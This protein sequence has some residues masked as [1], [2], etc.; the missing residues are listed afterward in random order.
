MCV[1][2]EP[3]RLISIDASGVYKVNLY[4]LGAHR[5]SPVYVDDRVPAKDDYV[6]G[7]GGWS[8]S[9]TKALSVLLKALTKV[10]GG[11]DSAEGGSDV[12][13]L[14][15]MLGGKTHYNLKDR[16]AIYKQVGGKTE[17][18]VYEFFH[19]KLLLKEGSGDTLWTETFAPGHTPPTKGLSWN[20]TA[21]IG[22]GFKHEIR[23]LITGHAYT[24][25]A[26]EKLKF[27]EKSSCSRKVGTPVYAVQLRNPWGVR[28]GQ[29]RNGQ[30]TGTLGMRDTCW[31][32]C[33]VQRCV[34]K[35]GTGKTATCSWKP[36]VTLSP[37]AGKTMGTFWMLLDDFLG[38]AS[39][40]QYI[41]LLCCNKVKLSSSCKRCMIHAKFMRRRLTHMGEISQSLGP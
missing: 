20:R 14:Q 15:R 29:N 4:D 41:D 35:D 33:K 19:K 5:W 16:A 26:V 8:N 27:L 28:R 17:K 11:Y 9:K 6:S 30:W 25:M 10:M 38:Q 24:V 13:V 32:T 31:T 2:Q 22:T 7:L 23:G 39:D 3:I 12:D 37:E 36:L 34:W 40:V 1:E 21:A 18:K